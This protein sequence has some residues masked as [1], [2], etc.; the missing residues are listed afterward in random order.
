MNVIEKNTGEKID[1]SMSGNIITFRDEL[2]FNLSKYERD[3][4]VELDVCEDTD[5]ILVI[6]MSDRYVAQLEIPARA[7]TET[8]QTIPTDQTDADGNPVND[9]VITKTPVPF[10]INSVTL[11]LWA[12]DGGSNNG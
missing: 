11:T 6:G 1:Y 5:Q 8:T 7:Y 3:Y 12:L 10:D 9:V 4:P 2:M